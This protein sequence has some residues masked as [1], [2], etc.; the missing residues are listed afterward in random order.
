MDRF[1]ADAI[2][3][4]SWQHYRTTLCDLEQTDDYLRSG[5]T[6]W[7]S[8]IGT[9][10]AAIA[11]DWLEMMQGILVLANP[12]GLISNLCFTGEA[13]GLGR[14]DNGLR[15]VLLLNTIVHGLNWQDRVLAE[16]ACLR[17]EGRIPDAAGTIH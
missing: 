1:E 8:S 16:T 7:I 11:W 6:V 13:K 14:V 10:R 15:K 4:S 2:P 17:A 5:S 9:L 12:N 3:A